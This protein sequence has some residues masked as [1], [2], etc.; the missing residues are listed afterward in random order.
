MQIITLFPVEKGRTP[1]VVRFSAD[2]GN[3][4]NDEF[5]LEREPGEYSYPAVIGIGVDYLVNGL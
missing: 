3:S 4:W 1:L 2:N 5:V